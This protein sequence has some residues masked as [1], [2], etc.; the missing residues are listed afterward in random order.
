MITPSLISPLIGAKGI[1]AQQN[2]DCKE[3]WGIFVTAVQLLISYMLSTYLLVYFLNQQCPTSTMLLLNN[4]LLMLFL[5]VLMDQQN[6][7]L[8]SVM[9]GVDWY[10]TTLMELKILIPLI[11]FLLIKFQGEKK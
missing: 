11:S 10:K 4:K 2:Q 1:Y 3:T 9:N 6:G 7:P 5:Q 8:L